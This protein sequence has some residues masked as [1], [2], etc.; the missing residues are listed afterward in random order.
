MNKSL[1]F[2]KDLLTKLDKK[3]MFKRQQMWRNL[4][5]ALGL[6]SSNFFVVRV[7]VSPSAI[8]FIENLQ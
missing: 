8:Y 5:D 7:R 1:K 2:F 4:V 6:D 3:I